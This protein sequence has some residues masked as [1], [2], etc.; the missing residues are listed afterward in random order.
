MGVGVDVL[1]ECFKQDHL[2][3]AV[4]ALAL[5][6]RGAGEDRLGVAAGLSADTRRLEPRLVDEEADDGVSPGVGEV[7]EVAPG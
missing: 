4:D 2:N 5:G 6:T 7:V 1:D 3:A